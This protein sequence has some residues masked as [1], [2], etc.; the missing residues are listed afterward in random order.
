[1]SNLEPYYMTLQILSLPSVL[2]NHLT[3]RS[4]EI[5]YIILNNIL[6]P[7]SLE[8]WCN[9]NLEMFEFF[10]ILNGSYLTYG[11]YFALIISLVTFLLSVITYLLGKW[12]YSSSKIKKKLKVDYIHK[13]FKIRVIQYFTS[14]L[15]L[16][17]CTQSYGSLFYYYFSIFHVYCN[18]ILDSI[19]YTSH[20]DYSNP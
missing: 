2:L 13:S 4:I 15:G 14:L 12:L 11:E 17:W 7:S 8:V 20:V 10:P 9:I 5:L 3:V 6:I 16:Q 19:Q 1:M 18:Y